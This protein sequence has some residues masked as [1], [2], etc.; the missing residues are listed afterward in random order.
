MPLPD[1]PR[2]P[3]TLA[4]E[5]VYARLP[6]WTVRGAARGE[7]LRDQDIAARLGVSRTPVREAR[8]RLEDEGFVEIALNRWTRVAPLDLT[9][10]AKLYPVI[11]ALDVLAL[12]QA[13]PR[14]TRDHLRRLEEAN[15]GLARAL[16]EHDATQALAVDDAFHQVSAEAAGHRT[17]TEVLGGSSS[18]C[19]GRNSRTLVMRRAGNAPW[20]NT[21]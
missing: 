16:V 4:R 3:R 17:L 5:E 11:E 1:T 7:V 8:R 2:L 13:G 15:A 6:D 18:R 9:R 10:A 19:A 20:A 12:E 14:L 21:R